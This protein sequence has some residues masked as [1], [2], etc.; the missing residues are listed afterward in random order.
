M[1]RVRANNAQR[2][3]SVIAFRVHNALNSLSNL[4][5]EISQQEMNRIPA[6]GCAVT[7][8]YSFQFFHEAHSQSVYFP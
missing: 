5:Q 3:S 4:I 6:K 8:S 1:A 7:S 2:K